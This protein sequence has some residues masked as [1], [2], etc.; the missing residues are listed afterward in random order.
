MTRSLRKA[1][2]AAALIAVPTALTM[3]YS[4]RVQGSDHADTVENVQRPG[5]DISD[6]YIFPKPDDASR[7]V[8]VMCVRPLI[9]AGQAN[10]VSFDPDVLYQ[11]KIDNSATLDGV[12]DLVIQ[13]KFGA[14]G[15]NQTVA[16]SGPAAPGTTGSAN[17]TQ[18]TANTTAGT[19][20]TPF[21][22]TANMRVFAGPRKDPFFIDLDRFLIEGAKSNSGD[23]QVI[24]PDRGVPAGLAQPPADPN[25]AMSTT[26]R[27]PGV[28]FLANLNV[29]SIVVEVPKSQIARRNG[30]TTALGKIGL[31][32]TTSVRR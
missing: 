7:V 19:K 6:V 1:G 12:E 26:F 27:N 16:I 9:P 5:A 21:N 31:W 14:P 23:P 2:L 8:L 30:N 32:T 18:L 10:T 15:P 28:D 22:P 4:A 24:L 17:N 13:A 29:L 20:G 25:Q 11:F 3:L